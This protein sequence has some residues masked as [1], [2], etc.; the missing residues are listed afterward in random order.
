MTGD[1][2]V[3]LGPEGSAN[4]MNGVMYLIRMSGSEMN[5]TQTE[6]AG[7]DSNGSEPYI[8]SIM[9]SQSATLLNVDGISGPVAY[10]AMADRVSNVTG[11]TTVMSQFSFVHPIAY[12]LDR[13]SQFYSYTSRWDLN[14]S[15]A[16]G[17]NVTVCTIYI[18]TMVHRIYQVTATGN[19][20]IGKMIPHVLYVGCSFS[21]TNLQEHAVYFSADELTLDN[22]TLS[23]E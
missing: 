10:G 21:V 5:L 3:S 9:S 22:F 20:E 12:S 8:P 4:Y 14:A 2:A 6:A 13:E 23:I 16:T 17:Y 19:D 15:T 7:E 1:Q 18:S 11:G